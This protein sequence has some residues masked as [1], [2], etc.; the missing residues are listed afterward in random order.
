MNENKNEVENDVEAHYI[1]QRTLERIKH[2]KYTAGERF[3][4]G[5]V[6]PESTLR[7]FAKEMGLTFCRTL[8]SYQIQILDYKNRLHVLATRRVS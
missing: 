7:A 8:P 2:V 3:K 6:Y 5:Q 1:I 4:V